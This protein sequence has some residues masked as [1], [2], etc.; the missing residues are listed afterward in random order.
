MKSLG[1]VHAQIWLLAR[2][3][4]FLCVWSGDWFYS[5]AM[6]RPFVPLQML[7]MKLFCVATIAFPFLVLSGYARL[8]L[9]NNDDR[10]IGGILWAASFLVVAS[11][12]LQG[13]I[14]YD[15]LYNPGEM[16]YWNGW[17][18]YSPFYMLLFIPCGVKVGKSSRLRQM[19]GKLRG[20]FCQSMGSDF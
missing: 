20:T 11:L 12:C 15:R 7:P 18:S 10:E 13:A 2:V 16:D 3:F 17:L 6:S 9:L 14:F 5:Y 4:P 1:S 8:K 19:G